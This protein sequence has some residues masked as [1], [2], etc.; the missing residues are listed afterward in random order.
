MTTGGV[1][2]WGADDEGQLGDGHYDNRP[3]PPTTDVLSDVRAIAA[4]PRHT[5]ALMKNWAVRCWGANDDGQL[6][7]GTRTLHTTPPATDVLTNVY[8]IVAGYNDTCA[9]L[10]TGGVRCWGDNEWGQAGEG[11]TGMCTTLCLTPPATDALS[12]AK[13]IAASTA[14]CALMTTGGVR[15]WGDNDLGQL[16]DGT[17]VYL[18]SPPLTDVLSGVQAIAMGGDHACALM[19]TSGVRCWGLNDSGQLG[20]GHSHHP[21]KP[22]GGR[23]P[24]EGAGHRD[25]RR[26]Y[27]R[28]D[29]DRRCPML[30]RQ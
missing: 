18:S 16:G 12:G 7:D 10:W 30:G 4:G 20:D 26:P 25:R 8:S 2:C 3:I 1:R 11:N 21:S 13:A 15:C 9:L 29:G 19:T 5:R 23:R 6:G 14:T 24:H 28:A 27:L 17:D 22:F